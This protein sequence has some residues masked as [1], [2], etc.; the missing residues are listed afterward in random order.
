MAKHLRT[1]QNDVS[2]NALRKRQEPPGEAFFWCSRV[3]L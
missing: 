2:I 1:K 3:Y